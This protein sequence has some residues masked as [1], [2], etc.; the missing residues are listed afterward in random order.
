MS[1]RVY[2]GL[3]GY[4]LAGAVFHAP[5]IRAIPRLRLAAIATRREGQ[6]MT[7]HSGVAVHPT[8]EVL[9]AEPGI[10]L[11]VIASP[12]ETHVPL[13][14][15]ALEAGKHVVVDKPFT[16]TSAEADE[17]IALAARRGRLLSV[18]QN[19]R[20]DA[21]FRTVRRCIEQGLLGEVASYEAHFD[22]FRPAIKQGWREEAAPGSGILYDLGAHLIDQALVL[23]GP[24][25]AVTADLLAQRPEARTVD[26]FHLTLDY[27]RRRVIVRSS[28][29]AC[30][31]GPRFAVHGD[32][33]SFLKYGI[34]G[35]E[36][37]LK[38]GKRP[39]TPEWG[40]E[41]PRWFGTLVTATGERRAIESLPGAYEAYY[42]GIADAILDGAPPPVRAE[43]ARDVIRIIEAAMQSSAERRTIPLE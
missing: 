34:D 15:A 10:D 28:T 25:R 7:D 5:L 13:A 14:R 38:A 22:R 26:Y 39:G 17:L 43:E 3:V 35:Q 20:W 37:A 31:P 9:I 42:E 12:N 23:F 8:P 2:V 19:R 1:Q 21:D 36:D 16:I 4:G 33:G 11:V 41:D 29:L 32:G 18:F 24:P 6:V 30:E 27:G 40:R